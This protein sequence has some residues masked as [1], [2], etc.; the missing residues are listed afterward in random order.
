MSKKEIKQYIDTLDAKNLVALCDDINVYRYQ[1]GSLEPDC[2]LN[3]LAEKLQYWEIKDLEE[4]ILEI[5][6]EKFHNIVSL[7]LKDNPVSYIK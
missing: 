4:M 3:R 7:L 6:H 5:A 1:T 2:D